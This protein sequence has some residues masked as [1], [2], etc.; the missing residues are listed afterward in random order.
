MDMSDRDRILERAV[1]V[2]RLI[3]QTPE[4]AYLRSAMRDIDGDEEA[5]ARLDSIREIQEKVI[6]FLEREEEPPE[7][8]RDE[9]GRISEEM[10]TSTRYQA[11]ISAQ[12]N[13]DKLMEKVNQSIAEGVKT[14]EQS[15]IILPS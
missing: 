4:Y 3:S 5:K 1:E 12:A 2:G 7:D 14:G 9:L 15:R 10:Q 13:F 8:L 11:L 6:G